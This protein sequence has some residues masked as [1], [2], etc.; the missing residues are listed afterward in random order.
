MII[1]FLICFLPC[2]VGG[3]LFKYDSSKMILSHSISSDLSGQSNRPLQTLLKSTLKI[4]I[5]RIDIFTWITYIFFI[6]IAFHT[7]YTRGLVSILNLGERNFFLLSRGWLIGTFFEILLSKSQKL[8]GAT[9]PLAPPL[10]RPLDSW[11]L[12]DHWS[13]VNFSQTTRDAYRSSSR[14]FS[15]IAMVDVIW[16]VIHRHIWIFL[17]GSETLTLFIFFASPYVFTLIDSQILGH[18][19]N[20]CS[21]K[22]LFPW[23]ILVVLPTF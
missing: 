8:R 4:E 20:Q 12:K 9:A 13:Y 5:H 15:D 7:C 18:F 23:L 22:Y 11:F 1:I 2:S 6:F 19:K 3:T 21:E 17:S 14:F 10:T 16:I